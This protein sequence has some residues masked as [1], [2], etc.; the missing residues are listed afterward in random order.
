LGIFATFSGNVCVCLETKEVKN[1]LESYTKYLV[2]DSKYVKVEYK[3]ENHFVKSQRLEQMA[4][5]RPPSWMENT[6]KNSTNEKKFISF[7]L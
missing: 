3:P 2:V 1:T 6:E 5:F 4:E 7:V